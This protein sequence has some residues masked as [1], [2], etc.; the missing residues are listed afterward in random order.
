MGLL[1]RRLKAAGNYPL[2]TQLADM[3]CASGVASSPGPATCNKVG[4]FTWS[5]VGRLLA[6]FMGSLGTKSFLALKGD[7]KS[8]NLAVEGRLT[9]DSSKPHNKLQNA[10]ARFVELNGSRP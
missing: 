4:A 1:N 5:E 7:A 8:E 6:S 10:T 3:R 2:S 9:V